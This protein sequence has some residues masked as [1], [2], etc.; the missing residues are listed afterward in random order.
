M[1]YFTT[2]FSSSWW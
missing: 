2:H 1:T